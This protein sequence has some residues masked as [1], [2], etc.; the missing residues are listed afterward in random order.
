MTTQNDKQVNVK[1]SND[2]MFT[3]VISI[4]CVGFGCAILAIFF[5]INEEQPTAYMDEVFHVE[6]A[7]TYCK[8]NFSK[9]CHDINY[10]NDQSYELFRFSGILKSPLHQA[11][12]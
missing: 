4:S 5:L 9:V 2:V 11:F 7:Q 10:I 8:G 3:K 6:Q 12:T 1:N